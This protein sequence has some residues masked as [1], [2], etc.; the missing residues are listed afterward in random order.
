MSLY[1]DSSA[2][3]KLVLTEPGS[4]EMEV[5]RDANEPIFSVGVTYVE[6]RAGLAMARRLGR[7]SSEHYPGQLE[8]VEQLWGE[9]LTVPVDT[10][11]ISRAG[12]DAEQFDLRGYDAVH[13]AALR[14]AGEPATI[15]LACWDRDLRAAAARLGYELLPERL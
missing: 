1:A 13:L 4:H 7:V 5:F 10:E 3:L 6:L 9:L 11:L 2:L 14:A 8:L 15:T 12:R